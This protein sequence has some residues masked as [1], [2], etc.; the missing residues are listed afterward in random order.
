MSDIISCS[1][2]VTIL[3]IKLYPYAMQH[4]HL[5][6]RLL[7]TG[8][9]L[10]YLLFLHLKWWWLEILMN[11]TWLLPEALMELT[12]LYCQM[13]QDIL[14]FEAVRNKIFYCTD[15]HTHHH[16]CKCFKVFI[17]IFTYSFKDISWYVSLIIFMVHFAVLSIICLWNQNMRSLL[18]WCGNYILLVYCR[19]HLHSVHLHH[20]WNSVHSSDHWSCD[21]VECSEYEQNWTL[22]FI[23]NKYLRSPIAVTPRFV[24]SLSLSIAKTRP[25]ILLARNT[26]IT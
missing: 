25:L 23:C 24:K 16:V 12:W 18:Y 5:H 26:S 1:M 15:M 7:E 19:N 22:L 4:L 14:G 13:S 17:F 8:K 6:C 20:R 2:L 10:E 9:D 21:S 3:I 11:L